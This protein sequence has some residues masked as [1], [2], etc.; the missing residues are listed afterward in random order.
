ML[1]LRFSKPSIKTYMDGKITV[2][3]YNCVLFDNN[4]KQTVKEF[5]VTG[6]SKCADT[7][8]PNADYGRKLADSRAK[9]S[10]YKEM[11]NLLPIRELNEMNA[12]IK[13]HCE[14]LSF[15][16]S[17]KYLRKKEQDHIEYLDTELQA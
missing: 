17:M 6:T 1:K 16:D 5:S 2:C 15:I 7:D 4:T 8:T 12:R 3:K 10:A 13:S 11:A 14:L 9:Y